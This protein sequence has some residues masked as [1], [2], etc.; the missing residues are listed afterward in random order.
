[1]SSLTSSDIPGTSISYRDNILARERIVYSLAADV[2]A[3]GHLATMVA[4][5]TL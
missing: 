5:Q 2:Q 4:P 1:M 3:I